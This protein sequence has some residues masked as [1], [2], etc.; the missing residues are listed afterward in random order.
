[1]KRGRKLYTIANSMTAVLSNITIML[2]SFGIKAILARKFATDYVGLEGYF[3]NVIGIFSFTE[4]GFS[5]ATAYCLFAPIHNEKYDL[6]ASIMKYIRKIYLIIGGAI[7]AVSLLFAIF[8]GLFTSGIAIATNEIRLYFLI[9]AFGTSISYIWSYQRI[10]IYAL[11]K[12]YVTTIVDTLS[13]LLSSIIS[14]AVI[15]YFDNYLLYLMI[16]TCGKIVENIVISKYE[17]MRVRLGVKNAGNLDPDTKHNILE[18]VKTLTY[19]N[20]CYL[21]VASTDNIIIAALLNGT[22]LAKNSVYATVVSACVAFTNALLH[23]V[24]AP[25]GDLV[26]EGNKLKIKEYADRY[27]FVYI[28]ISSMWTVGIGVLARTFVAI[29]VGQEFCFDVWT[30]II[31]AISVFFQIIQQPLGDLV[32]V[33]GLFIEY[34]KYAIGAPIINISLSV[35][36]TYFLGIRGVYIGTIFAYAYLAVTSFLVIHKNTYKISARKHT[37]IL[38]CALFLIILVYLVGNLL[39]IQ[40]S[41]GYIILYGMLIVLIHT[42]VAYIFWHKTNEYI[43]F[44]KFLKR[45]AIRKK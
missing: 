44:R 12:S 22:V 9:Y 45:L 14:I 19:E 21:G 18:Q 39:V 30:T 33:G 26:A 38:I 10:Y 15:I 42:L 7:A 25:I 27:I 35:V 34:K 41:I 29:W 11:Q 36:F 28:Y 32:N 13:R 24:S 20:V 5:I 1:M 8:I 17:S 37:R 43:Y 16:I 23:G 31:L 6:A 4:G 40:T 2:C 3:A